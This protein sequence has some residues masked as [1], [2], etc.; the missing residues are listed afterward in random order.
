M[1]S[2][3]PASASADF[4]DWLAVDRGEGRE[5]DVGLHRR[6]LDPTR[7]FAEIVLLTHARAFQEVRNVVR[8]LGQECSAVDLP[9]LAAAESVAWIREDER[10]FREVVNGRFWIRFT[11]AAL[12]RLLFD[13]AE[14]D[15]VI[16][17]LRTLDLLSGGAERPPCYEP[18][19]RRM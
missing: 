7:P 11:E 17:H 2:R 14:P 6:W 8:F 13:T 19:Q 4:V 16:G 12:R 1:A 3:W 15:K 9:G 10:R 18:Q 5:F